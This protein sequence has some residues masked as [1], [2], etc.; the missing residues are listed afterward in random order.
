MEKY[1]EL[2]R[3]LTDSNDRADAYWAELRTRL[4]QLPE[5]FTA[6][7]GL[8]PDERINLGGG[9]NKRVSGQVVGTA[10][11]TVLYDLEVIIHDQHS[12]STHFIVQLAFYLDNGIYR[13]KERNGEFKVDLS[14]LEDSTEFWDRACK[15]IFEQILRL[16]EA[17]AQPLVQ[18]A[19]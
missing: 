7:L 4:E 19:R 1:L 18:V 11:S 14:P 12:N 6:F 2:S 3:L 9:Y 13:L 10:N 15:R 17:R 16:T 5:R 8:D